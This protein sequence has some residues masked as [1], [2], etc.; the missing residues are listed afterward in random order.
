MKGI[1]AR[2]LGMT[3]I[4]SA[5]EGIV[6]PV[7]VLEVPAN[8]VLQV[9]SSERDGYSSIVLGAF[10]KKSSAKAKNPKGEKKN[11][12]TK[13]QFMHEV[14]D[15]EGEWK[16]GDSL[17][18][19]ILE[20]VKMV[21]ITGTSKGCGF[22]GVVKRY[23]FGG[24][25]ATHGSHHHREPGSVGMRAKPGRIL[26]GKRMPGHMGAE[27]VSLKCPIVEMDREKNLIAIKGAV[28]GAKNDFVFLYA[29]K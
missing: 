4:L 18:L 28:P 3:R 7:T 25:K 9:K 15:A 27:Q 29:T 19:D 24:G 6:V 16:K 13:F 26:R 22:T 20:G 21:R 14:R 11:L 8:K 12:S 2:K 23:H 5:E 1:L 10:E 17:T